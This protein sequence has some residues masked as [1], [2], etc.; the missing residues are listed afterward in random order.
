MIIWSGFGF[1]AA[2]IPFL[3]LLSA[4]L[5]AEAVTSNPNIYQE[6]MI[7]RALALLIAG[8]IVY[9]LGKWLNNRKLKTYI[10][11][12]TGKELTTKG[13]HSLFFIPIQYWGIIFIIGA[14]FY[15][16]IEVFN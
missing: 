9:L 3:F 15:I 7:P 6:N 11:K 12:E 14:I 4:Q 13:R 5:I 1:L 10:D 2:I 16:I 8:P